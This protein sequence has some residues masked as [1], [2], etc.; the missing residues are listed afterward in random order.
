MYLEDFVQNELPM[1]SDVFVL[2]KV[3]LTK[4]DLVEMNH[5]TRYL[6]QADSQEEPQNQSPRHRPSAEELGNT[7]VLD[8]SILFIGFTIGNDINTVSELLLL[9]I[10]S[11]DYEKILRRYDEFFVTATVSLFAES[12]PVR[13]PPPAA[14]EKKDEDSSRATLVVSFMVPI[15][16]IGFALG[17]VL[18]H[19]YKSGKWIPILSTQ[20]GG[21]IVRTTRSN[22]RNVFSFK[23]MVDQKISQEANDSF[24]SSDA[25]TAVAGTTNKTKANGE[26]RE[27][28]NSNKK[29]RIRFYSPNN[30]PVIGSFI[31]SP[32]MSDES[33]DRYD[34]NDNG[35]ASMFPP[36]IVID[37]IDSQDDSEAPTVGTATV[38][39]SRR[40]L[41]SKEQ[42]IALDAFATAFRESLRNHKDIAPTCLFF[43]AYKKSYDTTR[44]D[45]K[46]AEGE[47]RRS[48]FDLLFGSDSD[49]EEEDN[50]DDDDGCSIASTPVHSTK[51]MGKRPHRRSASFNAVDELS[52]KNAMRSPE[53]NES[54]KQSM[55]PVKMSL[56]R[57][58]TPSFTTTAAVLQSPPTPPEVTE[59]SRARGLPPIRR[60]I[61]S[62]HQDRIH[63]QEESSSS[64]SGT[65]PPASNHRKH[66]SLFSFS[67]IA[68]ALME[69][70]E[71]LKRTV[72]PHNHNKKGDVLGGHHRR[73]SSSSISDD[74]RMNSGGRHSGDDSVA[75][76]LS[77]GGDGSAVRLEFVAPR[78]GQLGLVLE[79]SSSSSSPMVFAVK[80]YSPLFGM[81]EKGDTLTEID[82]KKTKNLT[83][84]EVTKLLKSKQKSKTPS[85]VVSA[86]AYV[87]GRTN[88]TNN[89]N[90]LKI[91]VS[92]NRKT[93][94]ILPMPSS[95]NVSAANS[96]LELQQ[97]HNHNQRRRSGSISK[98][99][100]VDDF[101]AIDDETAS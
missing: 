76:M 85:S 1:N 54:T 64:R 82:G 41:S 19:K 24:V 98:L 69:S 58:E 101:V 22:H 44:E 47:T 3:E 46:A 8:V 91:V 57:T 15:V 42:E 26:S 68:K 21:D 23:Q 80:D 10:D 100:L 39:G 62:T 90:Q 36:M 84:T 9:G 65:P 20:I 73:K 50:G 29:R 60:P 59:R 99:L 31:M 96:K 33:E 72:L 95:T 55:I 7:K 11:Q 37:N 93:I 78:K 86:A 79:S 89:S 66:A 49:D 53:D 67:P 83:L 97:D 77:N 63:S 56:V 5:S 6:R 27:G 17:S 51:P 30:I 13:T 61:S 75:S 87:G 52:Q 38:S 14:A 25:E 48:S 40:V 34:T 45:T 92:R 71:T 74:L 12:G 18:Y 43:D 28:V 88:S 4:Q 70:S 81:V 94:P 32:I 2:E 35:Y 16:V